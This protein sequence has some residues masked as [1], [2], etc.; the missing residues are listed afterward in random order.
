P[1][2]IMVHSLDHA[3]KI[4]EL[5][6][7]ERRILVSSANPILLVT[8]KKECPLPRSLTWRVATVGLFLP[9]T[10]LHEWLLRAT[11]GPLV[12]TSGNVHDD[13]MHTCD[14]ELD[15]AVSA[16]ALDGILTHDRPIVR[17]VDDGVVRV[18][19]GQAVPFRIGRGFAPL[20]LP[21]IERWAA[22]KN[23]P[24]MLAVGGH[25]KVAVALWNG[26]QAVL[27]QH[28]GD[29][30]SPSSRGRFREI[31]DDLR[32]L[33]QLDRAQVVCDQH[34]DYFTSR[35]AD[36]LGEKSCRVQHHHAHA[37]S[38][39]VDND[40]LD[41]EV[42]AFTWDGTGL[43]AAGE[44][45]GGETL[46]A[47]VNHCSR[48]HS[49]LPFELLG[50]E[51]AI[52]EPA[53]VSLALLARA[54]GKEAIIGD[55]K[56]L[57]RLGFNRREAETLL[58]LRTSVNHSPRTSSMGRLFDGVAG[59]LLGVREVSYEG[60]AAAW[61]ESE[62]ETGEETTPFS[63]P[64]ESGPVSQGDWRP[65]V[66]QML[67]AVRRGDKA[68][69]LANRFHATLARWA[70]DAASH[71]DQIDVVLT[72]GCFQNRLLSEW[73]IEELAGL[74]RHVYLHRELPPNDGGLAVGQLAI[75]IGLSSR[76]E[77]A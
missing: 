75:A 7:V 56:L 45:W 44:L 51:A 22:S 43:G 66:R 41:R 54:A 53:R 27:S 77:F 47:S 13:P 23:C 18:I 38:C 59:L 40:L 32:R 6:E 26:S 4:A 63:M 65:M 2:A 35:W 48:S 29:M 39:M 62:A 12:V 50:G 5:N 17:A 57:S 58:R 69:D 72:G 37:V 19:S 64:T 20:P 3:A 8:R 46:I 70:R 49:L 10:P 34:P 30:S 74:G 28:L 21:A 60:E 55:D 71:H 11:D 52:H 1:L 36:N 31:V 25:Q 9:T 33:Y 61:L 73:M 15:D 14:E 67:E 16:G 24:P 42:L 76:T 68:S